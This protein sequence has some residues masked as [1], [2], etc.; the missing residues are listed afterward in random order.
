M[1]L[2]YKRGLVY[3]QLREKTRLNEIVKFGQSI[4]CWP[5]IARR[6]EEKKTMIHVL[7]FWPMII[8]HMDDY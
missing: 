5:A 4:V 7:S 2:V 6:K 3:F 1:R 8:E